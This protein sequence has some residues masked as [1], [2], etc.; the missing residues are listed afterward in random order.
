MLSSSP[1]IGT[2]K[3]TVYTLIKFMHDIIMDQSESL[4]LEQ[5]IH[6][7]IQVNRIEFVSWNMFQ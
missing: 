6:F 4:L 2:S 5:V 1:S 3:N 7:V